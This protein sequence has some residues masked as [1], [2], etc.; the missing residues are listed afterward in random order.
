VNNQCSVPHG[1]IVER[2]MTN[3]ASTYGED[4]RINAIPCPLAKP[5]RMTRKVL[6][7]QHEQ[8]GAGQA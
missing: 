4:G 1:A 2:P 7:L 5:V 6:A 3:T 8:M